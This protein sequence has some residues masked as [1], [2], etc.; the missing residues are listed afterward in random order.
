M[1]SVQYRNIASTIKTRF[2]NEQFIELFDVDLV[3]LPEHL[4]PWF[5]LNQRLMVCTFTTML[6]I[7]NLVLT[8]CPRVIGGGA[9]SA[10]QRRNLSRSEA[11][12]GARPD[13]RHG[14]S[15]R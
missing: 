3:T 12:I 5:V 7:A 11:C 15:R 13:S 10:R 8:S 4:P 2:E 14:E 1:V 9:T 6:Q